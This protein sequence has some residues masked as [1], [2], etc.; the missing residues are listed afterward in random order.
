ME[1]NLRKFTL[2]EMHSESVKILKDVADFCDKNDIHY[3]LMYG[4]LLGAIR[5]DGFIPWDDDIDIAMTREDYERFLATYK[6]AHGYKTFSYKSDPKYIFPFAK[7][8]NVNDSLKYE[9]IDNGAHVRGVEIDI[10]VFDKCPKSKI[11]RALTRLKVS[12]YRGMSDYARY[13]HHMENNKFVEPIRKIAKRKGT[14]Y[15]LKKLDKCTLKFNERD[16][17]FMWPACYP[18][19]MRNE[20][21][22]KDSFSKRVK[23]I[24]EGEYFYIPEDSN[25]VLTSLFG[26]NYMTPPPEN[27]RLPHPC[28]IYWKN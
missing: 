13:P 2:E 7:V 20:I 4:S 10:F 26:P 21:I 3:V 22:S 19:Q 14:L 16:Y 9:E 5:H 11:K 24:F 15:W 6:S 25:A 23:H 12:Y 28:E 1:K 8:S 18:T 27:E 17:D